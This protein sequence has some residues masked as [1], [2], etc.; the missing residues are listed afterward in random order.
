MKRQRL[1]PGDIAISVNTGLPE[2]DGLIVE[3][4]AVGVVDPSCGEHQRPLFC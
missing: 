2:N 3:I 4:L 1:Q